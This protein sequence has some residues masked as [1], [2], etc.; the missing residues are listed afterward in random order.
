MILLL[1]FLLK[2]YTEKIAIL[3]PSSLGGANRLGQQRRARRIHEAAL[4]MSR[5]QMAL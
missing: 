2:P 4:L 3:K 1:N 5:G